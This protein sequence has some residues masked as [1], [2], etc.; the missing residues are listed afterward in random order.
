[1]TVTTQAAGSAKPRQ[2]EVTATASVRQEQKNAYSSGFWRDLALIKTGESPAGDVA[3]LDK[4][5]RDMAVGDRLTFINFQPTH[6]LPQDRTPGSEPYT[7]RSPSSKEPYNAPAIYTGQVLSDPKGDSR[8][9]AVLLGHGASFG[10]TRDTVVLGGASG[11]EVVA[12]NGITKGVTT[13]VIEVTLPINQIEEQYNVDIQGEHTS[14][15]Q[16]AFVQP[17]NEMLLGALYKKLTPFKT[18]P[19]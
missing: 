7:E 13:G 14:T 4:K 3:Q 1:M 6:T 17:I 9:I 12:D 5:N 16:V 15:G 19:C 10:K 18:L 2:Q 11:G 8:Q